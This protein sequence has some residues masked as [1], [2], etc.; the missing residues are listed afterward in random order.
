MVRRAWSAALIGLL[1]WASVTSAQIEHTVLPSD[2]PPDHWAA[3]SWVKVSQYGVSPFPRSGGTKLLPQLDA[4]RLEL[5]RA[6]ILLATRIPALRSLARLPKNPPSRG[7]PPEDLPARVADASFLEIAVRSGV[8]SL[9]SGRVDLHAP[10]SRFDLVHLAYRAL[11]TAGI[12]PEEKLRGTNPFSDLPRASPSYLPVQ[13]II[14]TRLSRG[15]AGCLDWKFHGEKSVSR[16]QL[17][18]VLSDL[19]KRLEAERPPGH[20]TWQTRE[21][22]ARIEPVI[23]DSPVYSLDDLLSASTGESWLSGR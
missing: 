8:M 23:V 22:I 3:D 11:L 18:R 12:S 2:L 19:I 6:M 1:A 16:S 7:W 9:R 14:V 10:A 4:T 20:L 15:V 21:P 13:W 5:S 17:L